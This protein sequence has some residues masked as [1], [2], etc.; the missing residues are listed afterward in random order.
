MEQIIQSSSIKAGYVRSNNIFK[1]IFLRYRL[2]LFVV[3]LFMLNQLAV[4][5]NTEKDKEIV[6]GVLPMLSTEKLIARFGPMA[7]YLS[8]EIGIPIRLVTAPDFS[9]FLQRS[10]TGKRYDIMFTAPHMYYISQR[11]AGYKA[12]V[13]VAAHDMKAI[14]VVP[15]NSGIKTIQDL[16]GK[17]LS[18]TDSIA[19]ATLMIKAHLVKAGIDWEKDLKLIYTPSHN[20]SLVSAYKNIT[21]AGSLMIPPYKRAKKEIKKSMRVVSTTDGSPHMPLA[22]S[23]TL[24]KMT[25]TKIKNSLVNLKSSKEGKALLKHLRWPGFVSV[26]PKEYDKL[27][28]AVEQLK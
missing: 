28:W 18:T 11:K 26:E 21:D 17:T 27:K 14:I 20:A 4:A 8:K 10:N 23:S 25:V 22:V 13:R 24:D 15:E 6:F 7:D 5:A 19:L 12:I 1:E 2:Y 16:K 3:I 9:S